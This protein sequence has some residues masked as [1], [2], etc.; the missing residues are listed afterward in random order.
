MCKQDGLPFLE[1]LIKRSDRK[2]AGQPEGR[3][4]PG[5]ATKG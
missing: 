1:S 2:N 5:H 3:Q 4:L